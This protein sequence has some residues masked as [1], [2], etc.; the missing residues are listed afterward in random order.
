MLTFRTVQAVRIGRT[1][2]FMTT[3]WTSLK[4]HTASNCRSA[5]PEY[6]PEMKKRPDYLTA[7][8]N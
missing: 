7:V 2:L 6:T 4:K 3:F 1:H 5:C 8:L